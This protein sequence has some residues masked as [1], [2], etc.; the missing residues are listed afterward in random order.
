MLFALCL[1]RSHARPMSTERYTHGHVEPVMRSH[2]WRTAE[3]SAAY[4]LPHL[5]PGTS[6]LDVGCGPGNITVDLA[7]RV[8]PGHVVGIDA[9]ADAVAMATDAYAASH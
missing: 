5:A 1:L 4:L 8:A 2:R 6:L 9:A 7:G 3:N